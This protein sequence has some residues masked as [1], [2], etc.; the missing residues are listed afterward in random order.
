M[1]TSV[2]K[3]FLHEM[4]TD[5]KENQLLKFN[6]QLLSVLL[7]DR[8]THNNILW[9]TNNYAQKGEGF[10]D[11]DVISIAHI[12]GKNGNIIKPRINKSKETQLTRIKENAEVFT[13]AWV[14]NQ[15]N[16]LIDNAWFGRKDVFNKETQEGWRTIKRP[17]PFDEPITWQDY[18]RLTRLEIACGEAPYLTS[19]YDATTG[20]PIAV[21][22]RIGLLD[23]KLRVVSE[24]TRNQEDWFVWAKIAY[25]HIYGYDL[26]GDNVLLARENLLLTFAE[27]YTAR[28]SAL[29]TTELLLEIAEILSWNIWQMDGLKGVVPNSCYIEETFSQDLFGSISVKKECEGCAKNNIYKHNGVYCTIMDWQSGV[30]IKFIELLKQ[31]HVKIR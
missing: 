3:P 11:K 6:E 22:D 23:R 26:Q 16:N 27:Y 7:K 24:N 20:G 25:K 15:Q 31:K 10:R 28:F 13:P 8:T 19:R 9:A 5:V 14:C 29:P 4:N 2:K 12:T 30:P 18:V 21:E 17:I 1:T